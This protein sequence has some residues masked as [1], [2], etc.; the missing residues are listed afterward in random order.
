MR[1]RARV[2]VQ[3]LLWALGGWRDLGFGALRATEL[4]PIFTQPRIIS[5]L[6]S[7]FRGVA[8][9]FPDGGVVKEGEDQCSVVKVG[10]KPLN[11]KPKFFVWKSQAGQR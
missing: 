4:W 8:I 7:P 1:M 10:Q 3:P 6:P 5:E 2:D 9:Y 11:P